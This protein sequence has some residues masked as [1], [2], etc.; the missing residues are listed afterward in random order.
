MPKKLL[1]ASFN[2]RTTSERT[3]G[4]AAEAA[5]VMRAEYFDALDEDSF[6]GADRLDGQLFLQSSTKAIARFSK[7]CEYRWDILDVPS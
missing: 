1:V 2:G 5:A 7:D 4:T 6:D 3:Y